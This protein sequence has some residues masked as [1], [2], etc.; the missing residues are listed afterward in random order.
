M[1]LRTTRTAALFGVLVGAPVSAVG[2][3][4]PALADSSRL[5]PV[6][7]VGGIV[8]DG[9]H[10]RIFVSDP[11]QSKIVVTDYSGT[12]VGTKTDLPKVHGLALSADS[13][14]LY[15][16]VT[17]ADAIVSIATDTVTETA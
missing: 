8:V 9:V 7:S 15:A 5:L 2:A 11:F 10:Q 4:A 16:A 3:A 14:Q 12:V 17:G 6:R 13:G 1:Y